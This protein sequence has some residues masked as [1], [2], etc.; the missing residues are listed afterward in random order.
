MESPTEIRLGGE[1]QIQITNVVRPPISYDVRPRPG[2]QSF[3]ITSMG[4]SGDPA[5]GTGVLWMDAHLPSVSAYGKFLTNCTGCDVRVFDA[6]GAVETHRPDAK[7]RAAL[8]EWLDTASETESPID[9]INAARD[10]YRDPAVN[11][12]R[13]AHYCGTAARP[14]IGIG[15]VEITGKG[16]TA[17]DRSEI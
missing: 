17:A 12:Q 13:V 1:L 14:A 6:K 9:A 5:V 8:V 7:F 3:E 11:R 4:G 2:G 10:I 16:D 15:T